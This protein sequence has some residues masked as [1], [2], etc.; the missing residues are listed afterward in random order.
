M[1]QSK[2]DL[3][4]DLN[5]LSRGDPFFIGLRESGMWFC[6]YSKRHADVIHFEVVNG[7]WSGTICALTGQFLTDSRG[8]GNDDPTIR[9]VYTG[10]V[11]A[12]QLAN[13][14]NAIQYVHNLLARAEATEDLSDSSPSLSV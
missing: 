10:P 11:P 13:Y 2:S 7:S 3:Q 14:N 4:V 8:Q 1:A 5:A 6:R 12:K 9:V